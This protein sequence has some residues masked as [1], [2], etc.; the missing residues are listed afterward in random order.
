[1]SSLLFGQGFIVACV[2]AGPSTSEDSPVS[3]S[4]LTEPLYYRH[5]PLYLVLR[6]FWVPSSDLLMVTSL[7]TEPP[8]QAHILDF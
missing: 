1:M 6:G 3:A 2:L 5:G 4:P 7:C 8:P